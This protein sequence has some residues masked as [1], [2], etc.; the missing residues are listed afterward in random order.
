MIAV[1][2]GRGRIHH[3]L[4][5]AFFSSCKN[6]ER[7][8]N[9]NV[10]GG[11][12]IVDE[13]RHRAQSSLMRDEVYTGT[14]SYACFIAEDIAFYKLK[15]VVIQKGLDVPGTSGCQV[16]QYPYTAYPWILQ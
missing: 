11:K 6:I 14:R 7:T 16:V 4:Y 1:R 5:T 15:P 8:G 2:R 10:V 9:I 3:A 12:R 13:A